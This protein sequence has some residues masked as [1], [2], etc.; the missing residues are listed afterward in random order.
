MNCVYE[1]VHACVHVCVCMCV[2]GEEFL[3]SGTFYH[4]ENLKNRY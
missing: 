2:S 4:M 3:S 1:C